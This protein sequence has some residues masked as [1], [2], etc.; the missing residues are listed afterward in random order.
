M[1]FVSKGRPLKQGEFYLP[2]L[3]H[4]DAP[5]SLPGLI[6]RFVAQLGVLFDT[7]IYVP[8]YL[9]LSAFEDFAN[10]IHILARA[11]MT[12]DWIF[13]RFAPACAESMGMDLTGAKVSDVRLARYNL[14]LDEELAR[15]VREEAPFSR[16]TQTH[17]AHGGLTVHWLFVPMSNT[18]QTITHCLVMSACK[19]GKQHGYGQGTTNLG[20]YD[21]AMD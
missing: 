2:R 15:L 6:I 3:G 20:P 17:T 8:K 12:D 14:R 18:G 4:L 7:E 21:E 5:H 19:G 9:D 11:Q 1:P 10:Y 13:E 16:K